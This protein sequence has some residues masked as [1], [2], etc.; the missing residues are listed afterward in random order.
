ML[1]HRKILVVFGGNIGLINY[2][3]DLVRF[4]HKLRLSQIAGSMI[5]RR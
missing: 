1:L 4:E 3:S 2:W 5:I